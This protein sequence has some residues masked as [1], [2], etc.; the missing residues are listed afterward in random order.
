M[1]TFLFKVQNLSRVQTWSCLLRDS[2]AYT[3]LEHLNSRLDYHGC[4]Y[5]LDNVLLPHC[6]STTAVG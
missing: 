3:H 4:T 5:R 2:M 6:P 1:N